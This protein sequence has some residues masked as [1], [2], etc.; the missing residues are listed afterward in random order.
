MFLR[1]HLYWIRM[2]GERKQRPAV[3]LSADR[4]NQLA[5]SVVVVPVSTVPRRG[6]WNVSL[7]KGEG[8]LPRDSAVKCEEITTLAKDRLEPTPLGGA[9]AAQRLAEIRDAIL[10]ALDYQ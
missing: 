7:R 8:G 5:D 1:G 2:P 3:V 10:F 9:L 4:R 6:R